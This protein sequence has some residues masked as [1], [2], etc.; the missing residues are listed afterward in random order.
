MT[1]PT[2]GIF[3]RVFDPDT[4]AEVARRI[5][6]AGYRLAQVNLRAFGL[7]TMPSPDQ[8]ASIDLPAVRRD[9]AAHQVDTWGLSATYNMAHPDASVRAEGTARAV[10][11][12]ERA[13]ELGAGV[14]TLC[15]GSRNTENM[16][17]HHPDNADPAAWA[18]FRAELDTLLAAAQRAG[19]RLGVEPEGGNVVRD[20]RTAARLLAE[21]GAAAGSVA[22]VLDPANL[23]KDDPRSADDVL[24]EAFELLA[25]HTGCLHA[26]D[27]VPWDATL[28]GD[29]VVDY[30]RVGALRDRWTPDAPVIVQDAAPGNAAAVR[31]HVATRMAGTAS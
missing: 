4:P 8:W 17:R 9:L 6:D 2:F 28:A 13:A 29:G 11:S 31:E 21:L 15:T 14:V 3:A 18:D 27:L 23:L 1:T 5:R 25:E 12:I 19:V 16:W 24:D 10:L 26:K 20:A 30:A 7:P 22:I